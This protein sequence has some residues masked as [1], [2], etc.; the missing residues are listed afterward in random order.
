MDKTIKVLLVDDEQRFLS[1]TKKT[2]SKR[3]FGVILAENGRVAIEKLK[4]NPDIIILDIMMP[5]MDGLEALGEIKKRTPDMPVILLTGHD[6]LSFAQKARAGGAFD[7]LTKPCDLNLLCAKIR[8]ACRQDDESQSEEK[9]VMGVMVPLQE[10]SV[11]NKDKT[12]KD[13]ICQLREDFLAGMSTNRIMETAHRSM[14]VMDNDNNVNG[15]LAIKGLLE[16]IVDAEDNSRQSQLFRRGTFTRKVKNNAVLRIREIMLHTPLAVDGKA[17]LMEAAYKMTKNNVR[18][19]LVTLDG[20][21]IGVLREQDLF[22]EMEK[23]L[24]E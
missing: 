13:A 20:N 14:L 19:L 1:T 5:G 11:I 15:I 4:E 9:R 24:R 7:Y 10:Y 22:F 23:I 8:G 17:F 12:V 21:P 16:F 6:K 2:L 18:R 3:G